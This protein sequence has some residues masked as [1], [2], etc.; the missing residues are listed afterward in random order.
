[1]TVINNINDLKRFFSA[2]HSQNK[3]KVQYFCTH[4]ASGSIS[5]AAN[6]VEAVCGGCKMLKIAVPLI[7]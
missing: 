4:H 6:I 1:M 5:K 3:S 2:L 7:L